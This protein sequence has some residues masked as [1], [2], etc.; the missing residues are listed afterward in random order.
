MRD[1]TA[2]MNDAAEETKPSAAVVDPMI[3]LEC[4]VNSFTFSYNSLYGAVNCK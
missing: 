2:T 3:P 4:D 1:A